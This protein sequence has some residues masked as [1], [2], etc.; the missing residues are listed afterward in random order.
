MRRSEIER[1]LFYSTTI[2]VCAFIPLFSM[3]GPEG[4]L[5]GPMAN[6]YAFA[7]CGALLM[8]VTLAPVLCSFLFA[9]K[10]EAPDT[11]LDRIMK[12][13]YLRALSWVLR[14]RYLTLSVMIAL[15]VYTLFLIPHLGGE[16]MPPLEEG[17]LWIRATLPRTTSMEAAAKLAPE[18]RE[19]VAS[20]P[21]V[22]RVDLASRPPDDGTDVTGFFN[23][24]MGA[25]LKPM[26]EWRKRPV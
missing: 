8:A 3:S 9:N 5:F 16:F 1:A 18:L 26:E 11:F 2:I 15:F 7:I 21:E 17:Y 4:A 24:E 13:R 14:H 10:K 6:T 12:L 23:L 20:I 25:P 22:S 19:V